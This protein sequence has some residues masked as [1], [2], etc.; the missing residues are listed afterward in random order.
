MILI[1]N[2]VGLPQFL[3]G[4]LQLTPV[5]L[6]LRSHPVKG[7]HQYLELINGPD[8]DPVIQVASGQGPGTFYQRLK[9]HG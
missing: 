3:I 1:Q 5:L 6:Q 7:I 2:S 9:G 4:G 8:V